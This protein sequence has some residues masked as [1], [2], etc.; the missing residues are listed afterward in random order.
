MKLTIGDLRK[1]VRASLV[2]AGGGIKTI[3]NPQLGDP[4]V[5]LSKDLVIDIDTE[6]DEITSHLRDDHESDQGINGQLFDY[7]P[8]AVQDPYVR[9]SSPLPTPQIKR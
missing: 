1:L 6:E 7:K 8:I 3:R 4:M 5:A 9:F 2:E